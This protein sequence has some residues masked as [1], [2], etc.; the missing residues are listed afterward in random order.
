MEKLRRVEREGGFPAQ[1]EFGEN[2]VVF[3][4]QHPFLFILITALSLSLGNYHTPNPHP[5]PKLKE[6]E[7]DNRAYDLRPYK[8]SLEMLVCV[9]RY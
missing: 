5:Y 1:G 4:S 6:W 8:L 9:A 7:Q 2:A 3:A